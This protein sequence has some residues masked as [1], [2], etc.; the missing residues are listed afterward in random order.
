[1]KLE[2]AKKENEKIKKNEKLESNLT[3]I[4][5]K[6]SKLKIIIKE[7]KRNINLEVNLQS[8]VMEDGEEK[9]PNIIIRVE[10]YEEGTVYYWTAGTF[11]NRFD[12]MNDLF[13]RYYDNDVDLANITNE[14][15]PLWDEPVHSLLGYA[16]YKLEPLAYLM[17]NPSTI[18]IISPVGNVMGQLE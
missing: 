11:H 14:D 12:L 16:F 17:S 7:F 18:S 5:K 4:I 2:Q 10:N 1:M 13:D 15:D 3:I 9:T 8:N 6:L